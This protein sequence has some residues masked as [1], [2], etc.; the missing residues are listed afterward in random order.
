MVI[1]YDLYQI[2]FLFTLRYKLSCICTDLVSQ[3]LFGAPFRY[4]NSRDSTS[5][6]CA[7]SYME[8]CLEL[9]KGVLRI[10]S[11]FVYIAQME[12]NMDDRYTP[13][14]KANPDCSL[15]EMHLRTSI[16]IAHTAGDM[17][18]QVCTFLFFERWLLL[19]HNGD[20]FM[21]KEADLSVM[22]SVKTYRIWSG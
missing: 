10:Y 11:Q 3:N 2:F 22:E 12:Y 21:K 1:L 4:Y 14:I 16:P 9:L 18:A 13:E 15:T 19:F 6:C 20:K 8:Y 5:S 7:T 17:V